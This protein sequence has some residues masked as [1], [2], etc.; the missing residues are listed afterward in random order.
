MQPAA[1]Q[2]RQPGNRRFAGSVQPAQKGAL[3]RQPDAG[4]AIVNRRQQ[5]CHPAVRN[6][7][8]HPYGPLCDGWQHLVHLDRPPRDMCHAQPVQARHRQECRRCNPVFQFAQPGL[9][10]ATEFDKPQVRPPQCQLRP[11]PQAGRPDN[12]PLRKVRQPRNTG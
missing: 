11:P 1:I 10:I 3:C 7:P 12:C 6:P 9:H 2:N 4:R 5:L 8:L